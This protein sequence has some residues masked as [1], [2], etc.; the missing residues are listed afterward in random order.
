M[1]KS[2]LGLAAVV[3]V[4]FAVPTAGVLA[5]Q[6]EP[7]SERSAPAEAVR[8]DV[9][10]DAPNS[11]V[12]VDRASGKVRVAAPHTRVAVDPEAGRVR[13]RAPFVDLDIRW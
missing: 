9:R 6:P 12:D 10:V 11:R 8:P 2:R 13:V 3:A 1:R 4:L 5:Q 7:R